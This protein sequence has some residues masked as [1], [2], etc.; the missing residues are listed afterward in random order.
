M[1]FPFKSVVLA[2]KQIAGDFAWSEPDGPDKRL[3]LVAPLLVEGRVLRGLELIG[4]AQIGIRNADLS[5][6]MIYIPTD[7]RRDAIQLARI[8]WRPKAPHSN[9]HPS[10]PP[11]LAGLDI[12]GT[13]HHPFDLNWSTRNGQ[14]LRSLPTAEEIVPDY[15]S[16]KELVDGVGKF[17]RIQNAGSALKSPWPQDLFGA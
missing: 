9:D 10:A 3:R 12:F 5:F 14:P 4:R 1:S 11:H 7:N 8:D 17:F 2:E 16:F 15:Q 6:T 13:H